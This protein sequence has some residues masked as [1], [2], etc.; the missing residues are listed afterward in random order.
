MPKKVPPYNLLCLKKFVTGGVLVRHG[1]KSSIFKCEKKMPKNILKN[2]FFV[3]F[4]CL[5]PSPDPKLLFFSVTT[6]N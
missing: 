5:Q 2:S 3:I 4:F 1:Q 6:G